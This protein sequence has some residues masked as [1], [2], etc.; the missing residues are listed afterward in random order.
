M[1]YERLSEKKQQKNFFGLPKES[2]V[3]IK[4]LIDQDIVVMEYMN[5]VIRG[6]SKIAVKFCFLEGDETPKLFFT[7]SET[8]KDK[9]S[10]DEEYLPCVI[11]I[12]EK[13]NKGGRKYYTYE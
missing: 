6:E 8:I 7:R 13:V 9:L 12:R 4:D 10:S 1:E 5:V 3:S 2:R 11:T